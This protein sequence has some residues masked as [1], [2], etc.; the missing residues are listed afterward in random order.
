MHHKKQ[1]YAYALVAV[2]FSLLL[3]GATT[4]QAQDTQPA[5]KKKV[6][7]I[8]ASAFN[9]VGYAE[10]WNVQRTGGLLRSIPSGAPSSNIGH[11]HAPVILP[12][13]FKIHEIRFYSKNDDTPAIT[14]KLIR[15]TPNGGSNTETT[16]AV[17]EN[18]SNSGSTF[19]MKKIT[20]RSPHT[21]KNEGASYSLH[22]YLPDAEGSGVAFHHAEIVYSG[23]KW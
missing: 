10:D 13:K 15:N 17:V 22:L 2:A 4:I 6:L 8:P 5:A 11:F 23:K 3:I 21:V 1:V 19:A 18:P 20:L 12:D 16:L 9:E 14:L 7:S